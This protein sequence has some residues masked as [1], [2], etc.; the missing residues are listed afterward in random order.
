MLIIS[1]VWYTK[2]GDPDEISRSTVWLQSDS[3]LGM[4]EGAPF[5]PETLGYT[6]VRVLKRTPEGIRDNGLRF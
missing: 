5:H 3:D 1:V 4:A 2:I 6:V